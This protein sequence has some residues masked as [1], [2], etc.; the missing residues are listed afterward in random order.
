MG[1]LKR[2][3]EEDFK[4][5]LKETKEIEVST[6]K[7]LK[8]AIFNREKEKRYKISKEKP[9]LTQGELEKA[10]FL[11]DEEIQEVLTSEIKKRK[12]AITEFEKG[13]REDLVKKEKK[14]ISILKRYLP[15]EIAKEEIEKMAREIIKQ[16]EVK[17]IKE[18]GKVMKELMPKLRGKADGSLVSQIV[19]ELLS[20]K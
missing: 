4:K 12:E 13:K 11:T 18:M 19:K 8:A 14:E 5:A 15:K 6:L 16:L 10:S 7:L 9:T 17:E 1:I 20:Q 2:K 3:I